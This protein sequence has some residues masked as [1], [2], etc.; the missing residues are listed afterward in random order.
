MKKKTFSRV[1]YKERVLIE[2]RYCVDFKS[3]KAIAREL[4]RPL[5]TISRE[6]A[7][8][9]L[10]GSG[11]YNAD[12]AQR[13]ADEKRGNQGRNGKLEHH[14]T[15]KD[16]VVEKLKIGWSPEQ[17]SIRLPIEFSN[18]ETMRISYET[19][20]Q[21]IYNQHHRGGNGTLKSGC[22]D[23]RFL[24]A[25]RHKRRATKGARYAQK[26]ERLKALP[27]I[28]DRPCV[29]DKKKRIGDWEDDTLVS[30]QS[31]VR[32]KS[33]SER[34]SGIVF[35]SK[36]T[37]GTSASCDEVLRERLKKLP[38]EYLLTLTRDRGSENMDHKT[39]SED[40]GIDIFFTH[41]YC[42]HE[43]G[44]NEND[45]GLFRRYYP[46]G[47]DFDTLTD[48]EIAAV[49]YLINSRPRKRLGGLT[50]YEV[51]YQETGVALED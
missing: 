38:R 22:V 29:V 33:V 4:K 20:Y 43:R 44:H 42:S 3:K 17:I 51:F 41:P 40:L 26:L 11:R 13:V 30:R 28:E 45:N 47:T 36:T 6:I 31:L 21:Y 9:P 37:D 46:K 24:L 18:D 16:Y 39:L 2:N 32:I 23:L 1:T 27:S 48:E 50:P 19:I 34:R 15:L 5:S 8:R 12:V 7:G 10:R 49:E 25:R 35:F 14:D